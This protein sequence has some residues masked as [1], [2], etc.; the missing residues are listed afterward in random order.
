MP[1]SRQFSPSGKG[2]RIDITLVTVANS[3]DNG[4]ARPGTTLPCHFEFSPEA[5]QAFAKARWVQLI[6][7]LEGGPG[8]TILHWDD[9]NGYSDQ[10]SL[11]IAY[12][13]G[14]QGVFL[15]FAAAGISRFRLAPAEECGSFGVRDLQIY[16]VRRQQILLHL[17][18][19]YGLRA[20]RHPGYYCQ[21]AKELVA[22]WRIQ[23]GGAMRDIIQQYL[24]GADK[25]SLRAQI[26]TDSRRAKSHYTPLSTGRLAFIRPPGGQRRRRIAIGLVEHIGDIIACE[27]VARFVRRA[28]PDAEICWVVDKRYRE[29][30]D[31][32]PD[33]DTTIAVDCLTDWIKLLSHEVFDEYIDLH[34]NGHMC[35]PCGVPLRKRVGDRNVTGETYFF[36]GSLLEAFCLGA[37]LPP[38]REPPQLQIPPAIAANVDLLGLPWRFVALH[39]RTNDEEKDWAAKN[40]LSLAMWLREEWN[41]PVVE[42]GLTAVVASR[43]DTVLDLCSECSLLETAE[44]I[45]RAALFVGLD[46]APAHMANAVGTAGVVLMGS[47]RNFQSYNP[48]TGG[49][50]DGTRATLVRNPNGP[51]RLLTLDKVQ[52]A[53]AIRLGGGCGDRPP[54]SQDDPRSDRSTLR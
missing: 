46:S 31:A 15:W 45:R 5:P 49:F 30:I 35:R 28:N 25:N 17:L 36:H 9:G 11:T 21:M 47:L 51:T 22:I 10:K 23:G 12:R 41:L 40:W 26:R 2:S 32:N 3:H 27:P 53:V 37:G 1:S 18:G 50:A 48:F 4:D 52:E 38:L 42:V 24:S 13:P 44:V 54:P 6:F 7:H 19:M 14:V 43:I 39:C 16:P 33:V 34:V 8:R 20:I 29:L